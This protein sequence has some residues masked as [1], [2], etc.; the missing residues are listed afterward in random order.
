MKLNFIHKNFLIF[1][2]SGLVAVLVLAGTQV[3][4]T[5]RKLIEV[6]KNKLQ[7]VSDEFVSNAAAISRGEFDFVHNFMDTPYPNVILQYRAVGQIIEQLQ[8]LRMLRDPDYGIVIVDSH[9]NSK[10]SHKVKD[11]TLIALRS[12][13]SKPTT[14]ELIDLGD[15]IGF[16][17]PV[18]F[19]KDGQVRGY[20]VGIR[21]KDNFRK[22]IFEKYR[23]HTSAYHQFGPSLQIGF[24][25]RKI[26]FEPHFQA[27]MNNPNPSLEASKATFKSFLISICVAFCFLC[28]AAIF[29]AKSLR[30]TIN[31]VQRV[32]EGETEEVPD[33][34]VFAVI[35]KR[36]ID[37]RRRLREEQYTKAELKREKDLADAEVERSKAVADLARETIH[38]LRSSQHALKTFL[39]N[40]ERSAG[41]IKE[42]DRIYLR[43]AIKRTSDIING[44]KVE[45][46]SRESKVDT[47][48]RWGCHSVDSIIEQVVSERRLRWKAERGHVRIE[49]ASGDICYGIFSHISKI[50]LREALGNLI[51]NAVEAVSDYRSDGYVRL[52]LSKCNDGHR[53]VIEIEDNG[54]G[55]P[56]KLLSE[57][58]EK[59]VQST[60]EGGSGLGFS[61]ANKHINRIS[62]T[63]SLESKEKVGTKV[64]ILL[65]ISEP[66]KWFVPKISIKPGTTILTLDDIQLNHQIFED[67]LKD[68]GALTFGIKTQSFLRSE[69]FISWIRDHRADLSKKSF[70]FWVDKE[71]LGSSPDDGIQ[72]LADLRDKHGIDIIDRS[73]IVSNHY[74]DENTIKACEREGLGLVP[75]ALLPSVKIVVEDESDPSQG[76]QCEMESV[77][78][79][80]KAVRKEAIS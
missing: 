42:H 4:S 38:Q 18:R 76:L 41:T 58:G 56:P 48:S 32:I 11:I 40:I 21:S 69:D 8:S 68:A 59:S 78:A 49:N 7:S 80:S 46:E 67:R 5:D 39:K 3:F 22:S 31:Q 26:P 1:A 34:P 75:K 70:Q 12:T 47:G 66:P 9:Y 73:L 54:R 14:P 50:S 57:L 74:D 37:A 77:L 60:K 13:K 44:L 19:V 51:D 61:I 64:R 55:I 6:E 15:Y 27:G 36:H 52:R 17:V 71:L 79:R 30:S 45:Q 2:V 23:Q 24:P 16:Q 20:V 43:G 63:V 65:P 35:A 28:I 29:Q 72:V 53:A 25:G 10:L 62:G 33:E